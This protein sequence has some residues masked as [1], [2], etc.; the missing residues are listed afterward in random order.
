MYYGVAGAGKSSLMQHL[1]E[2]TEEAKVPHAAIDLGETGDVV[3]AMARMAGQLLHHR[4]ARF[5]SFKRAMTILAARHAG[6]M[7]VPI[8]G[9][10][11]PMASHCT[12]LM[13]DALD[14]L[15]E[16]GHVAMLVK[17]GKSAF[18]TAMHGALE[19]P[20]FRG[21]ALKVGGQQDLVELMDLPLP[22]L[23]TELERRFAADLCNSLP[24][25]EGKEVQGVLFLDTHE[26]LWHD[27]P[28]G[29]SAQDDWIR[30]L[31]EHVHQRGVLMVMAG[32]DRLDW[33]DD[34]RER[35]PLRGY[36]WLDELHIGGLPEGDAR[37]LIHK[38][39]AGNQDLPEPLTHA[40][41]KVTNENP[42]PGRSAHHCFLLTLCLEVVRETRRHQGAYPEPSVFDAIRPGHDAGC[43]LAERFL[44]SLQSQAMVSWLEELALTPHFDEEFALELD[45]ARQYQNG[46][47]GW[48]RLR[49]LTLV[50]ARGDGFLELHPLLRQALEARVGGQRSAV[51]HRWAYQFWTDRAETRLKQDGWYSFEASSWQEAI[52]SSVFH[53]IRMGEAPVET[54]PALVFARLV[55]NVFWWW[56]QCLPSRFWAQLFATVEQAL[57]P[58]AGGTLPMQLQEL[59]EVMGLLRWLDTAFP[60]GWSHRT[61]EA[62]VRERWGAAAA[63]QWSWAESVQCL[64]MLRTQLGLEAAERQIFQPDPE[65]G[66][67]LAAEVAALNANFLGLALVNR[68]EELVPDEAEPLLQ[69]AQHFF[70]VN[71]GWF[72]VLR[73]DRLAAAYARHNAGLLHQARR[74]WEASR[75]AADEAIKEVGPERFEE[76]CS[77]ELTAEAYRLRCSTYLREHCPLHAGDAMGRALTYGYGFQATDNDE[78]SDAYYA[79]LRSE[80]EARLLELNQTEPEAGTL[81]REGLRRQWQEDPP[82]RPGTPLDASAGPAAGLDFLPCPAGCTS[83]AEAERATAWFRQRAS[84]FRKD[85]PHSNASGS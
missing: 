53:L 72:G 11:A 7:A 30:T 36:E 80:A 43:R 54:R 70:E 6:E 85:E 4:H 8:T 31:R 61:D 3:S 18:Q 64:E 42:P 62:R 2:R 63:A 51:V 32:K 20:R 60:R 34:W 9:L 44:S 45:R 19:N 38:L 55:L 76:G 5:D 23:E 77:M 81:F 17:L 68:A 40:I 78:Y 82:P 1:Q 14:I 84:E 58:A 48:D 56:S 52:Q 75:R 27:G 49:R 73:Y 47:A 28:G 33:P 59:I 21:L 67:S 39:A 22:D 13:L 16:V 12:D 26:A 25:R 37:E 69:R 10:T 66:R 50:E 83:E 41:L 35:H 65:A 15:T 24:I 46:R 57:A 71:E 29:A 79:D 74:E